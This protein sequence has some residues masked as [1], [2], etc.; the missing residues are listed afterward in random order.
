MN[1]LRLNGFGDPAKVVALVTGP[2]LHAGRHEL[3]V[4][5]GD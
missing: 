1:A 2:E 5:L 3:V 4:A